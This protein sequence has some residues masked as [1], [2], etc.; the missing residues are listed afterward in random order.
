MSTLL[1]AAMFGTAVKALAFDGKPPQATGDSNPSETFEAPRITVP[2]SI[3]ELAKRQNVQTVLVGPDNTCGYVSGRSS[4]D[5]KARLRV[6]C[7]G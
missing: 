1:L 3:H 5:N 6:G 7:S 4:K 2:P